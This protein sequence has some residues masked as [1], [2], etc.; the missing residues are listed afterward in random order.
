MQ[1]PARLWADTNMKHIMD[2]GV[3][4][5]AKLLEPCSR[6]GWE[7]VGRHASAVLYRY[8]HR[9]KSNL[10]SPA[11]QAEIISRTEGWPE[12][13][14]F[15]PTLSIENKN[16]EMKLD[17]LPYFELPV[18]ADAR[19]KKRKYNLGKSYEKTL[20]WVR[21]N[22]EW[23]N[24][25]TLAATVGNARLMWEEALR[26]WYENDPLMRGRFKLNEWMSFWREKLLN[27]ARLE[28][29]STDILL[30]HFT[31]LMRERYPDYGLTNE[32]IGMLER[33]VGKL[34]QSEIMQWKVQY[35]FWMELSMYVIYPLTV[36]AGLLSPI[37]TD[38][39]LWEDDILALT[40]KDY[41]EPMPIY[42]ACSNIA[43]TELGRLLAMSYQT[44]NEDM[45]IWA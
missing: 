25:E 15:I 35:F 39:K 24:K 10:P 3:A 43:T 41:P 13:G 36:F 14:V 27:W 32:E 34:S 6:Q 19:S 26:Q 2:G 7:R 5:I 20:A 9:A 28:G 40:K 8:W 42:G 21:S 11:H 37:F 1:I 16:V 17:Y 18:Y 29:E 31:Q 4:E 12:G 45:K 22:S 38:Q 30:D 33:K 23:D 44:K